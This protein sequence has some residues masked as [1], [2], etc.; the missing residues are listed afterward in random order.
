VRNPFSTA[1]RENRRAQRDAARQSVLSQQTSQKQR[2]SPDGLRVVE[3]SGPITSMLRM[4]GMSS[5]YAAVYASQPNV[6]TA[7]QTVAR[8]A[9]SLT[10]KTY[11]K[12]SRIGSDL[13]ASRVEVD[14]EA[15][16]NLLR[17]PGGGVYPTSPYNFWYSV[18]ADIEIYDIAYLLKVRSAGIP[19]AL[20]RI[21]PAN[22]NL[23]RDPL[24]QTPE[25]F[26]DARGLRYEIN[27]LVVFW[28]YDPAV[29]RGNLPPMETIRRI[30]AEDVAAGQDREGRWR[31]SLRKDL[32][33][34]RD[35]DSKDM[36][37]ETKEAWM[38]DAEDALAGPLGSGRPLIG[39][40]G[41]SFKDFQWSPREMEYLN[42]RKLTRLEVASHFHI[43]PAMIGAAANNG[44]ATD[45]TLGYFYKSSLPPR[46][47]RVEDTLESQLLPEFYRE[48]RIRKLYYIEFNLD[49]KLRGSFEEKAAIM[50]TTVGGPVV[51]VNEGRARLNLPATSNPLDDEL[52]QPL[53]SLRGG[54]PLASPQNPTATPASQDPGSVEPAGTTPGGGSTREADS[55]ERL[56]KQALDAAARRTL[57]AEMRARYEERSRGIIERTFKRWDNA[58]KGGKPLDIDRWDRELGDDLFGMLVQA[59]GDDA[60]DVGEELKSYAHDIAVTIT[61]ERLTQGPTGIPQRYAK[62]I[63]GWIVKHH[64]LRRLREGTEYDEAI[65]RRGVLL[66]DNW[67]CAICKEPIADD[68]WQPGGDNTR[69]GTVDHIVP[70][71]EGGSHIWDN[72]QAVHYGCNSERWYESRRNPPAESGE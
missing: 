58:D 22:L 23:W 72:V 63:A 45:E 14:D 50:A 34:E 19:A 33:V 1:A 5:N 8:E 47:T 54:G 70:I 46:L 10:A 11:F 2:L 43:P 29:G 51:S 36:S 64:P 18:F 41:M 7:I 44:E 67:T 37:D 12:D 27:D 62:E 31:N 53:N 71:E 52:Y 39:E 35:K 69:Y 3:F 32:V 9:G 13:P 25:Y 6:R 66:R 20:V 4:Y 48:P 61:D 38:L 57:Q 60:L 16:A 68:T 55:P 17:D 21:P 40:P 15:V 65:T 30:I 28:G 26:L 24:T 42:A 56:L 49:E 59:A